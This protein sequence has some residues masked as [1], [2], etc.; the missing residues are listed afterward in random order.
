MTTARQDVRKED[1]RTKADPF[2][3]GAG[4]I[5]PGKP[6]QRG[7]LFQP[8]LVYQAGFDEYLG[9]LCDTAPE[10]FVAAFLEATLR[11]D[12]DSRTPLLSFINTDIAFA[13]DVMG[14]GSYHGFNVFRLQ[15]DGIPELLSSVVC[16]GGQGD[17]S[18]VDHLLF[19][20]VEQTRG[21]LD[22]GLEGVTGEVS[23]ERFRGLR[24]FDIRRWRIGEEVMPGRSYGI[25]FVNDDGEVETV[26]GDNRFFDAG[27]DYLWPIPLKELD[28]N[29]SLGQ[30]PGY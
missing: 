25:D 5:D 15:E 23:D 26:L 20:S 13:G 30:N 16:P 21:R 14:V 2:D 24:I 8:G 29:P 18:I 9:F 11:D 6:H 10:V 19:M 4:H 12:D 22:C 28:L 3:M 1:G 27:R 7:S 17:V